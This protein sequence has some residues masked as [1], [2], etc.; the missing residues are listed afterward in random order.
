[1]V[2]IRRSLKDLLAGAIF[3]GFGL[4]FALGALDYEVGTPLRMGPGY[5]PLALGLIQAGLG[6]L[7]VVKGL[8]AG[9]GEP[10]GTFDWRAAAFITA[11]LLFFGLTVRGL[12]VVLAL[13]GT[14]LLSAFARPATTRREALLIAVG[15]TVL[16]VVIFIIALRLRM[17]LFGQWLPI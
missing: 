10:I 7:I 8:L 2:E 12:G 4:A 17:P 15:I 6:V 11:A 14:V 16:S 3:I 5:M 1:V 9:E 13:F